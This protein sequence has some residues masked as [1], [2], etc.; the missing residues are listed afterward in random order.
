MI[1]VMDFLDNLFIHLPN[2]EPGAI[3]GLAAILDTL[4]EM[5]PALLTRNNIAVTPVAINALTYVWWRL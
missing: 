2:S 1:F 3:S 4:S 5:Q